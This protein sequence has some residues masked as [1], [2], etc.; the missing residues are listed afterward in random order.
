M[1]SSAL[2]PVRLSLFRKHSLATLTIA[3]L[4]AIVV[5][6]LL[7]I[8]YNQ[9]NIHPL[10]TPSQERRFWWTVIG[11]NV[12]I[13]FLLVGFWL[14]RLR[15]MKRVRDAIRNGEPV[16]DADLKTARV[17]AINAPWVIGLICAVGWLLCI[18][19]FIVSLSL[20]AEPLAPQVNYHLVVSFFVS[21]AIS[22]TQAFFIAEICC[23]KFLY[24]DFF[25]EGQRIAADG[26]IPGSLRV[27]WFVWVLSTVVCPVTAE[28]LLFLAPKSNPTDAFEFALA[29]A[30]I[31]M[32]FSFLS[33]WLLGRLIIEPVDR[34]KDAARRV[35]QGDLDARV[36]LR[37]ADDF[38]MLIDEFNKMVS[39]LKEKEHVQNMFGRHVGTRAARAIMESEAGVVGT[40]REITVMFLDVRDFTVLSESRKPT[41]VVELLNTL[42]QNMVEIVEQHGG[43]VNKFL[44]DGLM[45]LFG[46]IDA[47]GTETGNHAQAAVECGRAMVKRLEIVNRS[48]EL[49]AKFAIGIGI[50]T[51]EAVVG[52][53]GSNQRMEYTA[54]GDTVNVA[55]RVEGLTK[56]LAKAILFTD[57]T[58]RK[59]DASVKPQ[60]PFTEKVK[61]KS[62][63]IV[64]YS[65]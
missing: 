4:L 15:F 57:A 52:S 1:E 2:Q 28:L 51:G 9:A 44:G 53:I 14:N 5:G 16:S 29:V 17:R 49:S 65:V 19:V 34:L 25:P 40:T 13:Y 18:P 10:L 60:G 42:F 59:L 35:S 22:G 58:H 54:I 30:L 20:G 3:P 37:Q 8:W 63:E 31:F 62:A 23:L 6:S 45:A 33:A 43:M 56:R 24:A 47:E 64:V 48:D 26:G 32:V 27:K 61:G 55:A 36:S 7:N 21:G 46:A 50:H 11:Y 38:G 41:E 12:A 39:G